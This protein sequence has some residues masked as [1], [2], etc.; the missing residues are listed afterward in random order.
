VRALLADRRAGPAEAELALA[1]AAKSGTKGKNLAG[2]TIEVLASGHL[3]AN[4]ARELL[5][6]I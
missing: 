2:V 1:A 5:A 6:E 4:R 3:S